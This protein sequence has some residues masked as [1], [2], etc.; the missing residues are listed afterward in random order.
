MRRLGRAM[1]L[2]GDSVKDHKR[3]QKNRAKHKMADEPF[4][5]YLP[6][7]LEACQEH[8]YSYEYRHGVESYGAFTYALASTLRETRKVTFAGLIKK[9]T[10]KLKKIGYDQRPAILGP[11][12]IKKAQVPWMS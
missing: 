7:I 1:R 10:R 6:L 12:A 8:E 4:G 2:R 3:R 5:P 9:V 11:T